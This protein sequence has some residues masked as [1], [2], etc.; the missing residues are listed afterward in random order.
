MSQLMNGRVGQ[1][2][3][4]AVELATLLPEECFPARQ[5]QLLATLVRRRAPTW[6]LWRLCLLQ[7]GRVYRSRTELQDALGRPTD[8]T[9]PLEPL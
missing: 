6:A 7:P 9:V 2:V 3:E 1:R 5:D 4:R 8:G